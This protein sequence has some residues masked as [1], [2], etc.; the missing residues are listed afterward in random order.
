VDASIVAALLMPD[1]R[2]SG[3]VMVH[4]R[5]TEY[6]AIAPALLWYEIRNIILVNERRRRLSRGEVEDILVTLQRLPIQLMEPQHSDGAFV[7]A[8]RH[9]LSVYDASY[10]A[11][12]VAE[13]MPLATLD[14]AL[15]KA[16]RAERVELL[17]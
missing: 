2:P 5:M 9:S 4:A 17:G 10:L 3:A 7:L 8:Q 12:A 15:V 16:A 6:G 13:R 14:A 11:L 1:E